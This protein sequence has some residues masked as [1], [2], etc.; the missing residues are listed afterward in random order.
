MTEASFNFTN[1]E[2][3]IQFHLEQRPSG[4]VKRLPL[5]EWNDVASKD[6]AFAA[7]VLLNWQ[8][9]EDICCDADSITIPHKRIARLGRSM[10]TTLGLPPVSSFVLEV[11]GRGI[12]I[13]K[14][15]ILETRWLN[16]SGRTEIGIEQHGSILSL[17]SRK[18]LLTDPL[19]TL[20]ETIRE[21]NGTN[22]QS[23]AERLKAWAA[24]QDV[25]QIDKDSEIRPDEYL[26]KTRIAHAA[27]FSISLKV[28]EQNF[29]FDPVLFGPNIQ[30]PKLNASDTQPSEDEEPLSE[31]DQLLPPA[32]QDYFV[33]KIFN[34]NQKTDDRYVLEKGWYVVLDEAVQKSLDVVREVKSSDRETK[35]A[36]AKNPRAYLCNALGDDFDEAVLEN[37]FVETSEYSERVNDIGLWESHVLPWV[38]VSPNNWL[39]EIFGI[40]INDDIIYLEEPEIPDFLNELDEAKKLETPVITWKDITRQVSKDW[41]DKVLEILREPIPEPLPPPKGNGDGAT[42]IV[43]II[44]DNFEEPKFVRTR[45]PRK[46][47]ASE[48]LPRCLKTKPLMDHQLPAVK[49]LQSAWRKGQSGVLLADD[50]GLGK[51]LTCLTFLGWLRQAMEEKMHPAAPI[52]IVAPVGLLRN[53]EQEH[54]THLSRPGLGQCQH[55]HGS[56]LRLH[57]RSGNWKKE[58]AQGE[59]FLDMGFVKN[60]Q[61]VLTTYETLRDYQHSFGSVKFSVI[62]FDEMQRIK[63]PGTI[64]T[65]AAKAMNSDFTIGMTGTPIENRLAD[66]WCLVDTLE[67]GYLGDLRKFSQLYEKDED[68]AQLRKLK[69]LLDQPILDEQLK[70]YSAPVMKRR[71]KV[72]KLKGLPEKK[73]YVEKVEMPTQQRQEYSEEVAQARRGPR[74]GRM[75]KVIQNLKSISLHPYHPGQAEYP[76]Y[77]SK[78]GRFIGLFKILDKIAAKKE[79][80]LIFVESNDMK[81]PLAGFIKRRYKLSR[82][83]MIISG[84]V[85]GPKRQDRVNSF[86]S[87]TADTAEF[88]VMILSPKAGG[89]GLTLT[90]ANHVIHLSRWWNPAVE[91]QCTDRV[92]RIGQEKTVHV[93]YLQAIHPE[94]GNAS[95][96]VTLDA[97]LARKRSLS[98]NMLLP[99]VGRNDAEGLYEDTIGQG[100]Q[101]GED[102]QGSGNSAGAPSDLD[103]DEIDHMEPLQFENW[104][105]AWFGRAGYKVR[106][107]Q[108]SGDG[109][110]DLISTNRKVGKCLLVQCKHTQLGQLCSADVVGELMRAR[111][112][113]KEPDARLIAI[114]NAPGFSKKVEKSARDK[115][116]ELISRGQL[117]QWP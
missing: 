72:D 78:S 22:R 105:Q 19:F 92:F 100:D 85:A 94:Y 52:L 11:S 107:T 106:R 53:W 81:E 28:S 63:R 14:T 102:G 18:F 103:L 97:L 99:P 89:V 8:D 82:Q 35:R 23:S 36:F 76:D 77:L 5:G 91:D 87:D 112:A 1:S 64:I 15:F 12:V 104:C 58:I 26:V 110:A 50:M 111:E 75:L 9:D 45:A 27:A 68:E 79:K 93:Y 95:F 20:L 57:R 116:V 6:V 3:G 73:E 25:V 42:A 17:G 113:Y 56:N 37:I 65:H 96:D 33:E 98:R 90:A 24:I 34:R 61:W 31:E 40:K 44:E 109:G 39:P 101:I 83:P 7:A 71:L 30:I 62:V 80:A 32:Q 48:P 108:Q 74:K 10:T 16:M 55:A 54:D 114:T 49:W 43:L 60:A 51:T 86:Q 67:P 84:E 2:D 29:D 4:Q 21:F 13:Q 69:G 38:K 70:Q 59:S 66:L 41:I 117:G 115:G 46:G 88:D 47:E